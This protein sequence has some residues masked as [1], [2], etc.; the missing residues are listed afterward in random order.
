LTQPGLAACCEEYVRRIRKSVKLEIREVR[1]PAGRF[2]PSQRLKLEGERLLEAVPS[3]A[4]MVGLTRAGTAQS[5]EEFA[6]CL[7]RW[8]EEGRDVAFVIGGAY[9][10]DSN[11]LGRCDFRLSLSKFTFPHE[12]ARLILL[13]QLYRALTILAGSPYHKSAGQGL[14]G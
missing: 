7:G 1:T 2:H 3:G 6:R 11:V 4:L 13:E 12:L 10:L 14:A 9:G 8:R 5:S